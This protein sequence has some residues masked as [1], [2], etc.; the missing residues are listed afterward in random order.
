MGILALCIALNSLS[1]QS[2]TDTLMACIEVQDISEVTQI[3][4]V[5]SLDLL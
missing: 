1:A 2:I 5:S 3:F 4:T